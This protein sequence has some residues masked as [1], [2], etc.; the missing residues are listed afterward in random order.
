MRGMASFGKVFLFFILIMI[1]GF[2]SMKCSQKLP[3]LV[4]FLLAVRKYQTRAT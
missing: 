1:I 4:I 3:V 2:Y